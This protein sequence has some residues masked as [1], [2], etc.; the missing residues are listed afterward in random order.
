MAA[1]IYKRRQAKRGIMVVG[2]VA[3]VDH[4]LKIEALGLDQRE[5]NTFYSLLDR[6]FHHQAEEFLAD[7]LEGRGGG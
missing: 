3:M 1:S 5:N 4:T 6:G 2:V 7:F